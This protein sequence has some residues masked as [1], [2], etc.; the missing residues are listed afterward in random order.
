MNI[1][2]R[3]LIV[4]A[5]IVW[6]SASVT[7]A[8]PPCGRCSHRAG[9]EE[10]F[11]LFLDDFCHPHCAR[12]PYEERIETERHDFTQSTKTV[13]RGVVQLEGG[14]SYF[15]KSNEEDTENSHTTPELFLRVGLTEDI[16]FR[17]RWNYAWRFIDEED[18]VD[19]AEDFR[20]SLKLGI[21]EQRGFRPESALEVRSTA[22]TGGSA[23]STERVEFGL[24]YIY[25][26][27]ITET[28]SLYG[29][30][31]FG[32]NAL[33]DFGY[34]PEEPAADRFMAWSQSVALGCELSERNTLYSEFFGIFTSGLEDN[35]SP[36][37]F[38]IGID[39]YVTDDVI[40]DFRVGMG[41][42]QDADDFFAGVGGGCRF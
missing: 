13:G 40:V 21:T 36:V 9:E 25:G 38:N 12:D 42:N 28:T 20:W 19:G 5:I 41:L 7:S 14:Y 18:N 22:P 24:D 30:T 4:C 35:V 26:W 2:Y 29:S 27:E 8:A 31:G 37:L 11:F 32:S 39:H 10:P 34:L 33:G 17:V 23:W 6:T 1:R 3:L 15:H 16:E